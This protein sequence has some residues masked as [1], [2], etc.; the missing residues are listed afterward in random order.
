M[1]ITWREKRRVPESIEVDGT[2]HLV[3][4]MR[5]GILQT[6]EGLTIGYERIADCVLQPDGTYLSQIEIHPDQTAEEVA[7]RYFDQPGME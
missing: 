3:A 7:R 5:D 4:Y 6:A 1:I 2:V